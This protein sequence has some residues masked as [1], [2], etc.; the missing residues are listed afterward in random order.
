[1]NI[2][3]IIVS[4]IELHVIIFQCNIYKLWYLN[5]LE[6]YFI[7]NSLVLA[8]GTYYVELSTCNDYKRRINWAMC[9]D[10]IIIF[11]QVILPHSR[12]I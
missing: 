12:E 3:A 6:A 1:M 5:V 8:I 10:K 2:L 11:L 4:M 7:I 9:P